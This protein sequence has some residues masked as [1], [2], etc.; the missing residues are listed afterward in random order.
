LSFPKSDPY[1]FQEKPLGPQQIVPPPLCGT[2]D[3]P[4]GQS[5]HDVAH[6]ERA[7]DDG[8][9]L[10]EN[11]NP[12]STSDV[13]QRLG[14][15]V[16]STAM[17]GVADTPSANLFGLQ[18]ARLSRA[19]DDAASRTFIAPN[20]QSL[21]A[22]VGGMSAKTEP[23]VLEPDPTANVPGAYPLTLLSYAAIK[24]LQLS[25]AQRQ[26]YA[27]FLSYG[28][29]DG[30]VPGLE[31]GQLPVGYAPLPDFLKT[32]ALAAAKTIVEL[33]APAVAQGGSGTSGSID[34]PSPPIS[35]GSLPSSSGSL[36]TPPD[37]SSGLPSPSDAATVTSPGAALPATGTSSP[38]KRVLTPAVATPVTRFGIPALAALA[39]L[40]ALGFLEIT[41]RP[42]R[43]VRP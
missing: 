29:S 7:A 17:L 28:V 23:A 10:S 27:A 24:P 18:T 34:V 42:R 32:Q 35:S 38:L 37:L 25:D 31:F 15:Q 30:Q 43:S 41:K 16:I 39:L 14:P 2:D 26:E 1:C 3:M 6:S 36:P 4:Y 21:T 33:K 8:A 40:A 11:S 12:L 20:Q 22:A 9:K 5:F 19:G 13:W